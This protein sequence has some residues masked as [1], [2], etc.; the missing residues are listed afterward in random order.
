MTLY[1]IDSTF[2]RRNNYCGQL[3]TVHTV[4]QTQMHAHTTY[5]PGTVTYNGLQTP[6][7]I[8]FN[9]FEHYIHARQAGTTVS[10]KVY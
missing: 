7:S 1:F 10:L 8:K 3:V 6:V 2:W 5:I 4:T 9:Q